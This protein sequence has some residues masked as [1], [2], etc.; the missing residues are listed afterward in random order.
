MDVNWLSYDKNG[1]LTAKWLLPEGYVSIN[2]SYDRSN[3]LTT[4]T[5]HG[6]LNETYRYDYRTRRIARSESSKGQSI[7]TFNGGTSAAEWQNGALPD[8]GPNRTTVPSVEYIR[9]SDWGG[10]VGG[11]LYTIPE[12]GRV[13]YNAYNSRGDVVARVGESETG[14]FLDS[15]V[16][17]QGAYEAY[18]K[19]VEEYGQ[20]DL[21]QMANTKEEDPTG[22]LNEGFRYRDLETGIWL[23]R[24]PAGFVDG[25]NV[26]TY[27]RQN[28]WSAFDPHGL[29]LSWVLELSLI[30]I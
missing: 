20:T 4:V 14:D 12:V 11:I 17:W 8:I 23:T 1:N 13:S 26:Y 3:R 5:G 30:H 25:P 28:P 19:R 6:G 29:F 9:G 18:G 2:Y 22:L 21:R 7:V 15:E 27:V 16:T 10:G 24:D